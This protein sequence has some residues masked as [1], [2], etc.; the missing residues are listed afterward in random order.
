MNSGI[1]MILGP[2]N[3]EYIG[4]AVNI[5]KRWVQHRS[6]L[7]LGIH[8]NKHLQSAWYKYGEFAFTFTV[9]EYCD[10][11][12][13]LERE[14]VHLDALFAFSDNPYN[15]LPTA[16][17]N[18]GRKWSDETKSKQSKAKQGKRLSESTRKLISEALKKYTFTDIHKN[19]ISKNSK[20][21]NAKT[22]VFISPDNK[23][24][25]ITNLDEFCRNNKLNRSHM[26]NV[27]YGRHAQHKG[28][29]RYEQ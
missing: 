10:R 7:N 6:D 28:W 11:S 29:R 13:L 16:G 3:G 20:G 14:Q 27:Y 26:C 9:L 2:N 22:F 4:S 18:L 23:I 25:N 8:K 15:I 1:Y 24:V 21:K 12:V 17:S 19:N 5:N